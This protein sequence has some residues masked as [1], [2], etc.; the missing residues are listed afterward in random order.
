MADG[1]CCIRRQI[2]INS[3][4]KRGLSLRPDSRLCSSYIDG[5]LDEH[6]NVDR[7]VEEC[8]LMHWLYTY[9]DYPIKLAEAYNFFSSFFPSG[10]SVKDYVK[11][12]VQPVIKLGTIKTYGGLPKTWPWLLTSLT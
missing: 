12:N 3:L 10:K 7:V 5:T 2:L 1:R 8:A 6:W 4:S 9:T 11:D